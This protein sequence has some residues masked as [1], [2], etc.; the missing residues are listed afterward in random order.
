MT[1]LRR[2]LLCCG[3]ALLGANA[4]GDEIRNWSAPPYWSGPV[5]VRAPEESRVG[6]GTEAAE[7]VEGL[8]RSAGRFVAIVP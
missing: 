6:V 5:R 2:F 1:N 4:W 7:A 8:P 3:I